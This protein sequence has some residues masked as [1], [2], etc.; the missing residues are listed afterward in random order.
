MEP[1]GREGLTVPHQASREYILPVPCWRLLRGRNGKI[2]T[3]SED[4]ADTPQS[5]E[6]VQVDGQDGS[7]SYRRFD[8]PGLREQ[9]PPS[10]LEAKRKNFLLNL[11][12][13]ILP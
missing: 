7:T 3:G 8:G 6:F 1:S 2:L 13:A 12:P 4:A 11:T 10:D 9:L 5:V